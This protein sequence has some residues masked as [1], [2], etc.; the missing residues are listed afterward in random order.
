[1]REM[2]PFASHS[3]KIEDGLFRTIFEEASAPAVIV[4]LDGTL[5]EANRAAR[6]ARGI[7][8]ARLVVRADVRALRAEA[9][10]AGR[11]SGDIQVAGDAG[12]ASVSVE[13]VRHGEVVVM[14]M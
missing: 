6:D 1:M 14:T 13:A 2:A 5:L 3:S 7:D 11:A 12:E 9:V 10:D 8:Y 4:E